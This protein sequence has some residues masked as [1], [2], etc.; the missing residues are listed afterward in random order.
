MDYP[1]FEVLIFP[2]EKDKVHTWPK[3]KIIA[4]GKVGPAEKRD[5]ALKYA[6]GKVL[7]FLD[8]DAY[9]ERDWL[10]IMTP[11]F[12]DSN[13]GAVG[14]PA[15]TPNHD[16]ILQ[17]VSGAVFESY[18]GGGPARN[19]YL[20]AGKKKECDDWPTVNLLVWRDVFAE[21]G[22]FDSS[23]WP[24]ED[25]KLC[26]DIINAG[27]KIIY[28]P[29]GV[30]YHHRRADLLKH[31][32]QI[33]S[34][35]LHRGHFAKKYPKTSLKIGYFIPTLFCLYL[36]F[37]I[38][39]LFRISDFGFRILLS[40]PLLAY[41]LGL[42]ADAIIISLRWKNILIGLLTI[43]MIFLTHIWYGI[44][45]VWGLIIKKLDR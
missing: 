34:Y 9:P 24:G 4:S 38:S 14:G 11:L 23:F 6:K 27:Y 28:D 16:G 40:L 42:I 29:E 36:I 39:I 3:T 45:F 37:W 2:D 19:R 10:K 18:L 25:T 43:P 1:N 31:F 41:I 15:I 17:K 13:I 20:S 44:R 33:G 30:V 35:A 21:V 32:K 26:L 7:A 22:G 5:L 12:R 8:D